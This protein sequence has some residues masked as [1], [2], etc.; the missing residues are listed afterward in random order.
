MMIS[1]ILL[2]D[3][4]LDIGEKANLANQ[5]YY[6]LC[7][8]KI[9]YCEFYTW[10]YSKVVP[11]ISQGTRNIVILKYGCQIAGIVITKNQLEKKICTLRVNP[12][13][14]KN[15]VGKILIENAFNILET[16]KPIIT[17]S[18]YRVF[19]FRRILN[20]YGFKLEKVYKNYYKDFRSEFSYNGLLNQGK[21]QYLVSQN[22]EKIMAL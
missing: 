6:Q 22:K 12:K 8:L 1:K 2:S 19:E 15:G 11:Q 7:D 3:V 20:Y 14:Q 16:E 17:V 9:D 13:Y 10:Y 4:N 5:I 21:D 18:D